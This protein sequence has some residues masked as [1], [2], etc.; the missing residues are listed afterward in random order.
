MTTRELPPEEWHRLTETQLPA[1]MPHIAPRDVS[2]VVVEDG[3]TIVGAVALMWMPHFEGAWVAPSYRK[4]GTVFARLV[5]AL[6]EMAQGRGVSWGMAGS[7]NDD[8]ARMLTKHLH[9]KRVEM[10]T[11]IVH[12]DQRC[13]H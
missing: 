4:R 13:R 8:M 1:L 2:V 11:Y 10:D 3:D 12:T 9:A 5:N 6:F 7:A